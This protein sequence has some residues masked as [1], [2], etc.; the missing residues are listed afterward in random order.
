MDDDKKR[1]SQHASAQ[2][3]EVQNKDFQAALK[4]LLEA[5]RPILEADLALAKDPKQLQEQAIRRCPPSCEEEL[6]LANQ[7]FDKFFTKDVA[8]SLLPEEGRGRFAAVN[9]D[10]CFWHIRC[11]LVFGWLVCRAPR[12]FRA[13]IY[14][15][16]RYWICIRFAN[17]P[18][19]RPL[20]EE[21]RHDFETLVKALAG[22][23]KPYLTDQLATVE[24]T[25]GLP[26]A[27][28]DG[29][30]DCFEDDELLARV[31]DRLLSVDAA[32]ALLGKEAFERHSKESIFG[33]CR[34]WCL[35][36]IRFGC[37]LAHARSAHDL[38]CCLLEYRR[39]IRD[40]FRPLICD[41]TNPGA[42]AC[43]EATF[44][45]SC[46]PLVAIEIDGT[47]S[48]TSFHH[49]T[50]S[51]SWGG[52]APVTD[53][54]VYPD[55][56]RPPAQTSSTVQVGSGT[57][58]YLDA[59]LLPPG[60]TEF[61]VYLDVFDASGGKVSCSQTF[62]VKTTAIEISAVAKVADLVAEDP[63]NPGSFIKLIKAVGDPNPAVPEVSIGGAFS[64]DGSAYTTGCDRI[65]TQFLMSSF[66]L[67]P[68]V[69]VPTFPS[70]AGGTQL[71][72][73][74]AVVYD[75]IPGHPWQ[76]GC[77][78]V[79]TPNIILNGDLVAA[80]GSLSC[81]FLGIPYTEPKVL[82]SP[83]WNSGSL[84]GRF[85]LQ[86]EVRDSLVTPRTFPGDVA[87]VDQV[88]VWIDN[89]VPVGLIKSIGGI[90][91]C[92]DLH[93]K[94]F[95]G[96][97]AEIL[98]QA[99]DPPIDVIVVQQRPNDNF[100][101]YGITFEKNG[102]PLATGT[103]VAGS[104]TRVPN[105]WPGPLGGAVGTLADWDIVAALDGGPGPLPPHSPKLARGDR[106]AY[107]VVMYVSDT[108]HVGDSG[109]NHTTGPILYALNIIND[110]P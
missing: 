13:F 40:C 11:C 92:G 68:L 25:A 31:F 28:I 53:A 5:Y 93:L 89:Q 83:F 29:K 64:V 86:L 103:I 95:V 94:D 104:T 21:E 14:Y 34:C 75:D 72:P 110:I 62:K 6:A 106:C 65:M 49:Y 108:T 57:L 91:G 50:L 18:I 54:V 84:N 33:F 47:A 19:E 9:W 99:W 76:S 77:F 56:H 35:C 37:C 42:N 71:L 60:E 17:K 88:A 81:S 24:F 1:S 90:S 70:A 97:T 23:Y 12:T 27:V 22:A 79:M 7:L 43:A 63:F 8:L 48:G 16:Y 52:G 4:A 32:R 36:S 69:P 98:G 109:S 46:A 100:G 59:T 3:D 82:A 55:C 80:W 2:P 15:L 96:T 107:V 10:W 30:I 78:P 58:G 73:S 101:S 44:I 39:C 105:I 87:G 20:T 51:Y 74:G 102:D 26:D 38:W 67:N 45:V 41:I 61:T 85:V 66:T